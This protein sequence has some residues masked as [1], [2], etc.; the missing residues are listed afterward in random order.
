MTVDAAGAVALLRAAR[1]AA[2]AAHCPYSGLAVGA[3]VLADNGRVF[4]GCNVENASYGL[5]LC[6][7]RV[8]VAAA[9]TSGARRLVAAAVW[10]AAG[11]IVPCGACRQV[12]AE[13]AP[14]PPAVGALGDGAA[15]AP[16]GEDPGAGLSVVLGDPDGW[17]EVLSLWDLLPRPFLP[18]AGENPAHS[19]GPAPRGTGW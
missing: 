11:A 4:A 8:A 7:E 15:A 12:L 19:G 18:R 5:T 3:A 2:A 14:R 13:F 16:G 17:V 9:V 6:A 10:S 1:A